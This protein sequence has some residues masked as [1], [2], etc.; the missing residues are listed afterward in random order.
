MAKKYLL[1]VEDKVFGRFVDV[2]EF[3]DFGEAMGTMLHNVEVDKKNKIDNNHRLC[4]VVVE[5]EVENGKA[6]KK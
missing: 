3:D 6:R 2:S 4:E 1:Q 5:I